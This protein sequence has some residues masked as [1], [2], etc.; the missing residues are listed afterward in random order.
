MINLKKQTFFQPPNI[1]VISYNREI[2]DG[3]DRP[4][5]TKFL[6]CQF[7]QSYGTVISFL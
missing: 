1:L 3:S 4:E 7:T 5:K 6:N 2:G